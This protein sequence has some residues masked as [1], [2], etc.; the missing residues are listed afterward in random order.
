MNWE[1]AALGGLMILDTGLICL[2][3]DFGRALLWSHKRRTKSMETAD[4]Y[5][6]VFP[7]EVLAAV[8][9]GEVDL[10][11]LARVVL[12]GRG[13]DQQARWV[14]FKEATRLQEHGY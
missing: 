13:L 7:S 8:A 6:S 3:C 4:Q 1:P 12:A 9:R 11:E 2:L 5:M 14:G 10:N